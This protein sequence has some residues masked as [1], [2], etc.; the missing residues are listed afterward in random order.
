MRKFFKWCKAEIKIIIQ[1][2]EFSFLMIGKDVEI[3]DVF[4]NALS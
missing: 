3:R 1:G 2:L 4:D